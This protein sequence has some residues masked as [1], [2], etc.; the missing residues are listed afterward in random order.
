MSS[1]PFF[2]RVQ[3]SHALQRKL[4]LRESVSVIETGELAASLKCRCQLLEQ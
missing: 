4:E 2:V 1:H 3:F